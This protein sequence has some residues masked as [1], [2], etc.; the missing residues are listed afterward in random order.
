MMEPKHIKTLLD[1][2]FSRLGAPVRIWHERVDIFFKEIN[3]KNL[4][5]ITLFR[6]GLILKQPL[7][8][9]GILEGERD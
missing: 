7:E 8:H 1:L 5:F 9:A 2:G 3:G 4:Y 6:R